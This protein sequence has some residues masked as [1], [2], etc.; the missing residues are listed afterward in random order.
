MTRDAAPMAL[1]AV[2]LLTLGC[3]EPMGPYPAE[4]TVSPS[5]VHLSS[6]GDTQRLRSGTEVGG[7]F[8]FGPF[9]SFRYLEAPGAGPRRRFEVFDPG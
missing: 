3:G 2:F 5:S 8:E 7:D 6:L 1:A 9:G 4:I